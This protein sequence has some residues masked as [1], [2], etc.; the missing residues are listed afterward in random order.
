MRWLITGARGQLGT[1]LVAQL[2][3]SGAGDAVIALGRGDLDITDAAA[4]LAAV[5]AA[6]PDVVVNAAAYTA[7]D[8][9]ETDEG[10][11]FLVNAAAVDHLGRATQALGAR[12]IQVS[13]D[14]VFRGD[15][16][17]PY[18]PDDPTD[19]RTAYGRSKL[20][21]ETAA[22]A[23]GGDVVRTAW[24]YGGPGT[25]FV[26]TMLRLAVE[27]PTVDVVSDQIGSPTYVGDLAVGLIELGRS[28]LAPA[29]LHYANA[30]QAS[31]YDL[32]RAVFARGGHDPDRVHPVDSAQFVR[33]APRPSWSVLS[34]DAWAA[35]GLTPPCG[36]TV[37]LDRCVGLATAR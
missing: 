29:V 13:T 32:A 12:L 16:D 26:D 21:G 36:W 1:H 8:A 18:Q 30:G 33:P 6:R 17:R 25:N 31:W 15:A 10:A 37:A 20:A 35:S 24:V 4:V 9:A 2:T 3:A 19:P 5:R 14:Y 7:V 28:Q 11:A 34:T 22:R 27:R 23:H